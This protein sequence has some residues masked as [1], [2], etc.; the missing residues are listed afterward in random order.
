VAQEL[1]QVFRIGAVVDRERLVEADLPGVEA[2]EAGT[3]AVEGAAPGQA[4]RRL[5]RRQ[6]ERIVQHPADAALHL[7]G[8]APG[9]GQQQ[10]PARVGAGED[11]PGDPRGQGQGLARAG[12]GDDEKRWVRQAAR[13]DAER[14]GAALG[15]VE[16]GWG[17]GGHARTVVPSSSHPNQH[18]VARR[19]FISAPRCR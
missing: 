2:K 8:C 10:Q 13:V 15:F 6:A 14:G 7:D 19:S 17:E 16:V 12:A 4:G 5:R 11:E 18:R 3:D 1:D 9:E